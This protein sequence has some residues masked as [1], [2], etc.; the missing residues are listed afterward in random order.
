MQTLKLADNLFPAIREGY[1]RN[2]IRKGRRDI[3]LGLLRLEGAEDESLTIVV[4]VTSVTFIRLCNVSQEDMESDG[5]LDHA[6]ML[7]QMRRFYPDI[8]LATEVTVIN[9]V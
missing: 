3:G 1:K 8:T 5:F 7:V 2:T 4:E 6:D 9:F